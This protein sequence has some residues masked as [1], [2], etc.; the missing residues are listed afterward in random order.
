MGK[1]ARPWPTGMRA[2]KTASPSGCPRWGQQEV[3][4]QGL[5]AAGSGGLYRFHCRADQLQHTS[6]VTGVLW[7]VAVLLVWSGSNPSIK[8]LG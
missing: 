8:V 3:R 7:Q 6:R 4:G 5:G 2:R 1:L